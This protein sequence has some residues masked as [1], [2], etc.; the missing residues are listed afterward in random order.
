MADIAPVYDMRDMLTQPDISAM[1]LEIRDLGRIFGREAEAES[2]ATDLENR[3]EAYIRL[4]PDNRSSVATIRLDDPETGR[5][6]VAPGCETIIGQFADCAYSG[7]DWLPTT[8]EGVL[9]IDADVLLVEDYVNDPGTFTPEEYA[10]VALWSDIRAVQNGSVYVLTPQE[11]TAFSPIALRGM[12]DAIPSILYP[13]I[14]PAP[15]TDE[16]VTEILAGESAASAYTI[17]DVNGNTLTFDEP[18]AR[19]VSVGNRDIEMLAALGI[20]PAA[21]AELDYLIEMVNNPVYFPQPTEFEVLPLDEETYEPDLE[22]LLAFAPDLVFGGDELRIAADGLDLNVY[23][24]YANNGPSDWRDGIEELRKLAMLT[25]REEQ[26]EAVIAQFEDRLAAYKALAPL[27]R[28]VMLVGAASATE[29][30]IS[31]EVSGR[32]GI[33]REVATCPWPDPTGGESWSYV[34]SLEG[35]LELNPDVI[36]LDNWGE[37][38]DGEMNAVLAESALWNELTAVQ[39]GRVTPILESYNYVQGVGPIGNMRW[40]DLY[41]PVIYPEVFPTPLTDEQVADILAEGQ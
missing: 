16:Q 6:W 15:L 13:D 10:E 2:I 9:S 24:F 25:E 14:V 8:A 17:T 40:L 20:V 35:I 31:T 18:P 28:S 38:T 34:T 7:T 39:A 5:I 37:W 41:M 32:C 19:F 4:A 23:A 27:D 26:A 11:A 29:F 21:V 22:A 30:Y 36:I 33:I 12:L 1:L 3:F